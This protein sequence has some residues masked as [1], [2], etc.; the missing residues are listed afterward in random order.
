MQEWL[1]RIR[2]LTLFSVIPAPIENFANKKTPLAEVG[3]KSLILKLPRL[4]GEVKASSRRA[5]LHYKL[6]KPGAWPLTSFSF[7]RQART[8]GR[9]RGKTLRSLIASNCG[10]IVNQWY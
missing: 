3:D 5:L 4:G 7:I 9:A 8:L 10:S 6:T 1:R 2:G